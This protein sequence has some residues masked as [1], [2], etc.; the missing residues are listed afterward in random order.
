MR[1]AAGASDQ[2]LALQATLAGEHAAVWAC[3]RAA[4]ELSGRGQADALAELKAHRRAREDLT[5]RIVAR[6]G[7]PV[8]AAPAYVEPTPVTNAATARGLLA[9]VDSRL[10]ALYTDLAGTLDRGARTGD[11]QAAV[12]AAVRAQRWG[13]APSAFPGG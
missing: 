12:R 1:P 2:L 7:T 8:E 9:G 4:A 3:G 10:G 13:Q 11:A 5:A 6:G